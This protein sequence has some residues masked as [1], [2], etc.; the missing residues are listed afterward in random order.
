[1]GGAGL[2]AVAVV[3]IL[4][5]SS[6]EAAAL[7]FIDTA[8]LIVGSTGA[9]HVNHGPAP[10][11]GNPHT[12]KCAADLEKVVDDEAALQKSPEFQAVVKSAAFQA[13]EADIAKVRADKCVLL[14][15]SAACLTDLN[16]IS[17]DLKALLASAEVKAL[18]ASADF[19]QV[20]ADV[21]A[22]ASDGCKIS[23]TITIP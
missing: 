15:L 9:H 14:N 7:L 1:M 5:A 21:A 6:D 17:F 12:R 23:I 10:R 16:Q 18:V 20:Q 3:D 8:A 19:Q 11:C 2:A 13:L 4:Q 22:F